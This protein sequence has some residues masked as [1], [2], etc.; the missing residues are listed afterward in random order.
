MP[1]LGPPRI[2]INPEAEVTGADVL[3]VPLKVVRDAPG[4][5]LGLNN[6]DSRFEAATIWTGNSAAR[7]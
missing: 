1:P 2:D 5:P 7:S 3:M 6:G 4:V